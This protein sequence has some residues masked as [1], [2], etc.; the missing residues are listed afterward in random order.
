MT[1]GYHCD[2]QAESDLC[3]ADIQVK[4]KERLERQDVQARISG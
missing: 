3:S 4:Q 2:S 1:G